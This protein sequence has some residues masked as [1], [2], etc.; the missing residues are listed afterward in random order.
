MASLVLICLIWV[1][2]L[3]TAFCSTA[4]ADHLWIL[5]LAWLVLPVEKQQQKRACGISA[6]GSAELLYPHL[7]ILCW[8]SKIITWSEAGMLIWKPVFVHIQCL[9][10][11]KGFG[12]MHC[13]QV[14]RI[15]P[16]AGAA[17]WVT[18]CLCAQTEMLAFSLPKEIYLK[19]DVF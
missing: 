9:N 16:G 13:E 19:T 17:P 7:P 3:W 12:E 10:S 1:M 15:S 11:G 4:H 8:L 14:W 5:L 2:Y 6:R 18:Q